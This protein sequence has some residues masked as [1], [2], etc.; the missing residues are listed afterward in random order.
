MHYSLKPRLALL[1]TLVVIHVTIYVVDADEKMRSNTKGELSGCVCS[2][3][4]GG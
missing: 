3:S 4:V 2:N 1:E